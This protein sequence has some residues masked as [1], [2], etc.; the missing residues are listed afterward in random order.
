MHSYKEHFN[1]TIRLAL[2]VSI[3]QLGH[4]LLGVADS[5][6]VGKVGPVPLAAS[7]LV[8]GLVWL[9]LVFGIGLTLAISPLVAIE[10]GRKK[11]HECGPILQQALPLN[12]AVALLLTL[13]VYFLADFIPFLNQSPEVA[14]EAVSYAKIIAI[15]ILPFMIFQTFRQYIEGL[16]FMKPAMYIVLVTN[17]VNVFG[18]W[19][20]IYGNLGLPA[21]GLDGA[22]YATLIS[23]IFMMCV[24]IIYF[25]NSGRLKKF[26]PGLIVKRINRI[27]LN[28]L[29]YIGMPSGF[30]HFFEIGAFSISA[31]FIGWLGSN[32]LA[33]HQIALSMASI[34]FMIILGL[35]SASTIRVGNAV[36]R[37]SAPDIRR[38][39][40]TALILAVSVM[41]IFG[42]IFVLF[43]NFLPTLFISNTDVIAITSS[44]LI[45]AALF[46]ISDGIQAVG[47][48]VLRGITDVKIPAI[49]TF[50]AYW[51]IGLPIG[52]LMG[53]TAGYGVVGVWLGFFA[54]LSMAGIF[55]VLRFRY[56]TANA[57]EI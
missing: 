37:E 17:L 30:Q 47:L 32:E 55:F 33:A 21:Y 49:I 7:S 51:I 48:G 20:F 29:I 39:G 40:Y 57:P 19:V 42:I 43:R 14:G 53:F 52:Y 26:R 50:V 11:T 9:V 23:R 44:L 46:Q 24:I 13:G 41:S 36:G 12:T 34:S 35:T 28:K 10:R 27:V 4:I 5:L 1:E 25:L 56:K 54:G 22:G 2:P 45:I 16:S 15:S 38:A 31:V 3:G 18:N 8:H 6:M